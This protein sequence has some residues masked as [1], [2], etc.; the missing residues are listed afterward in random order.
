[1][2]RDGKE[3]ALLKTGALERAIFNS[4]NFSCIATDASGV[5]QIFNVGAERMLGYAAADVTNKITPAHISD[6]RE[7]IA[8]ASALSLE[9][10]TPIAPGFESLVFKAA[11]GIEDIYELTYIRKDGSRF[12]AVV[13]VTALR[14]AGEAI[15]GYLLIGTDNTARKQIE[16]ERATFERALQQKNAELEAARRMK[17][18][19]LA[20]MSHELRTPL[21]AVIGFSDV[22]KVGLTGEMTKQQRG[23]IGDIFDSGN[24][25]LALINEILDLSQL[26]AGKMMLDLEPVPM[27]ALLASAVSEVEA[28][29]VSRRI[30]VTMDRTGDLGLVRADARKVKQIADNLLSNAVKFTPEGG[31]VTIDARRVLRSEVGKLARPWDGRSLAL[32]ASGFA[33]FL[34]IGVTD[35][36]IGVAP[37]ALGDLFSPFRQVDTGLGR[38][39]Q[40]P[41][42]GLVMVKLLTELHGGTVAVESAPGEGSR[43]TVWLPLRTPPGRAPPAE[44]GEATELSLVA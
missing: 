2:T 14:D 30:R 1:V 26:E 16:E 25:L 44:I 27:L 31:E 37:E 5:I 42:L 18:D 24:R 40:G 41:G 4:A 19:F 8:R 9:L 7:M 29:A 17:S 36:G 22:L 39:F 38:K 10:G 13:S 35:N 34:E 15:I 33:E 20:T 11:R 12:P 3:E 6:R 28:R 21:N 23:L 43:F 32:A